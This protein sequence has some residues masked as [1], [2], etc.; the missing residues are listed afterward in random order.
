MPRALAIA[1]VLVLVLLSL[2]ILVSM[3]GMD[4]CPACPG[5][6]MLGAWGL[7][8][9]VI[10]LFTMFLPGATTAL[11]VRSPAPRPRLAISGIERPPRSA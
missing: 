1:L 3:G 4:P 10:S 9:A 8:L 7:C 6:G 2:P 11:G 5:A